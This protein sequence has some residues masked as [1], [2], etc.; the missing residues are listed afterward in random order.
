M[1]ITLVPYDNNWP[2]L[3][4][5]EQARLKNILASLDPVVEHIGSTSVPGLCAKPIIDIMVGFRSFDCLV[6][7]AQLL[8]QPGYIYFR[9]YEDTMPY[10]RYFVKTAF[11]LAHLPRV[12]NRGDEA[13]EELT[14]NRMYHIHMVEINSPFW[15]DHLQFR[16]YLR[17]NDEAC[18]AY[19]LLKEKLAERDWKDGNEYAAA[20][21]GF[22][23]SVLEKA[24]HE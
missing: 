17:W 24:R 1:K 16:N 11:T 23:R 5:E 2:R 18:T 20:K 21:A 10:R 9:K 22:I 7:A 15:K 6:K 13:P 8:Q 14:D 12:I 4:K 3:Y 19:S